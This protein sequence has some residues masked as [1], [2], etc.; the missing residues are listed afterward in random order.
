M[1]AVAR[2]LLS[3]Q[4]IRIPSVFWR[5][6]GTASTRPPS[7]QPPSPPAAKSPAANAPEPILDQSDNTKYQA[8]QVHHYND[9][10]FYDIEGEMDQLRLKQPSNKDKFEPNL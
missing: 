6:E 4:V 2:R 9:M 1:A 8:E 7:S 3:R 10:S 5:K